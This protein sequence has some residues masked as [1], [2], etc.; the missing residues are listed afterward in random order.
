V[1][2]VVRLHSVATKAKRDKD[3]CEHCAWRPP[4]A[5]LLHAHHVIPMGCGGEDKASNIL[6][7]C[8]NCHALA[9]YVAPRTNTLRQ[10][11]G[12]KTA[13]ELRVWMHASKN[14][15]KLKALQRQHML[16]SVAP[17]L[18]AMRA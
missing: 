8:P 11:S 2:R 17:M 3:Y 16:A 5:R 1:R 14:K 9:H 4:V 12:P 15:A 10:Y 18:E 13:L 7:L 6:V